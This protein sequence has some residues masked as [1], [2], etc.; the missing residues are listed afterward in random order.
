MGKDKLTDLAT[1]KGILYQYI[2]LYERWSEDRQQFAALGAEIQKTR[3]AFD[4]AFNRV[5][6]I[7]F[8]IL[9]AVDEKMKNMMTSL[10]AHAK[11]VTDKHCH[12]YFDNDQQALL[13]GI[14]DRF[15]D[16]IQQL[17]DENHKIIEQTKQ[18]TQE[19]EEKNTFWQWRN[20]TSRLVFIG[21]TVIVSVFVGV[22]T[23]NRLLPDRIYQV[24]SL[25]IASM[26]YGEDFLAYYDH[27]P[28]RKKLALNQKLSD[29][30]LARLKQDYEF[31][32]PLKKLKEARDSG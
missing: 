5:N 2:N 24:D 31:N 10:L 25:A 8:K 30:E 13:Q 28:K 15:S 21:V 27:L 19:L 6:Q 11:T 23:A 3:I 7:D 17:D 16:M 29:I 22:I 18:L 32:H 9:S 12:A 26:Q 14:A 4:E 1:L 20:F